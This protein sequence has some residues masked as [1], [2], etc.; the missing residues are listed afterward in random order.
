M[1]YTCI[2]GFNQSEHFNGQISAMLHV[3]IYPSTI[4]VFLFLYSEFQICLL[5]NVTVMFHLL[6]AL[7]IASVNYRL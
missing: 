6:G 7:L 5:R 1:Q 2:I 3:F 4:D